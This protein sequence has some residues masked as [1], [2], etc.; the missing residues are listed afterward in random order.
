M[1]DAR[2]RYGDRDQFVRGE[3]VSVIRPDGSKFV[4][5]DTSTYRTTVLPPQVPAEGRSS[6]L[7]GLGLD[8]PSEALR[9]ASDPDT[10]RWM[11][12]PVS[13]VEVNRWLDPGGFR[14][15]LMED[16]RWGVRREER[17]PVSRA[18]GRGF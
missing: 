12:E 4:Q 10:A 7:E 13:W 14:V 6:R 9:M 5:G 2:Y 18:D 17:H 15:R 3:L 8:R 1:T 16:T 11:T